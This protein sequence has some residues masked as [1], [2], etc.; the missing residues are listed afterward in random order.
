[1]L[2]NQIP[3]SFESCGPT[4]P[5]NRFILK[6]QGNCS[7]RLEFSDAG[8]YVRFQHVGVRVNETVIRSAWPHVAIDLAEDGTVVGIEC[9]PIVS[10]G[11]ASKLLADVKSGKFAAGVDCDWATIKKTVKSRRRSPRTKRP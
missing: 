7:P 9:V 2:P 8:L 11:V 3:A 1:M 10:A 4:M 6:A 5:K